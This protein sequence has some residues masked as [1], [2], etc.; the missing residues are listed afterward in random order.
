V[1][2]SVVIVT[3]LS[4]AG[5]TV[6]L[7]AFEDCGY[8]CTDNLPPALIDNY[9]KISAASDIT[10][11]AIG[12]DIREKGFLSG[13]DSA[14]GKLKRVCNLEVIFVE[15]EK[16]TLIRRFRETRRPHPLAE[17]FK[18]DI[19][20]AI[21]S[22]M[23]FLRPLRDA[24]DRIIDTTPFTPHQLRDE[25]TSVYCR[26]GRD[27]MNVI[28]TSFGY[29]FGLPPHAD[30]VF[31]VRFLQNPHF[32]S[33]L[34]ELSGMDEAVR[35][36]VFA[37]LKTSVFMEKLMGLLDFLVPLYLKEGKSYLN[38][39]IGCTGGKHRSVAI[40]ERLAAHLKQFPCNLEIIH[41][42]I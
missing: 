1:S 3:G 16:D 26:G 30:L 15:A 8:F 11:I 29:K 38:I 17:K 41:R 21:E 7:R 27:A 20:G 28:L 40:V 32:V 42:D 34:R 24:A 2:V 36:Y 5:K 10:S 14:I 6:A 18:S 37:D 31:D 13:V 9:I 35:D 19:A 23:S 39:C 22:E 25:I 4:G 33:E 12:I